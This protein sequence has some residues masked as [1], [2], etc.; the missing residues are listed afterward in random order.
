[1]TTQPRVSIVIAAYNY[2]RYLA[3]TL[4][5]VE[6]QTFDQWECIVVDDASTD[7]TREVVE[8]FVDRDPR[9]QYLGLDRNLGVSAARNTGLAAAK[10]EYIQLL[11]ADDQ[12]APQ[13]LEHH[14]A[15]LVEHPEVSIVYSGHIRFTQVPRFTDPSE[16]PMADQVSGVAALRRGIKGNFL[17]LNTVLF[18]SNILRVVNGF[19]EEFR[20]AEDWDFWLRAMAAGSVVSFLNDERAKA[21]VRDTVGS[22]SKDLPAMRAFHLPV[23]QSLWVNRNLDP[24]HRVSLL[25]RYVDF[26]WEMI[27]VKRERV[28]ILPEGRWP[29]LGLVSITAALSLPLWVLVRLF[30]KR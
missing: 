3:D 7:G 27:L 10:G 15:Y 26:M 23:R 6:Q 20:Y 24:R 17:R 18:R 28:I 14:L 2:G 8:R 25:L 30:I 9:F 16:L 19:R 1:M 21:A 4:R 22:L 29:F 5:S 13:K 12:I 11:D